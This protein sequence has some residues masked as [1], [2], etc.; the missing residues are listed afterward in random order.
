MDDNFGKGSMED[1]KF[2]EAQR[3]LTQMYNTF[4]NALI[5]KNQVEEICI[6]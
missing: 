5:E 4:L 6:K 1:E 3:V 2:I